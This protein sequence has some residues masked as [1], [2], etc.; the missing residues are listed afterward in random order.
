M[1]TR[2]AS[3]RWSVGHLRRTHRADDK[4]RPASPVT[5]KSAGRGAPRRRRAAEQRDEFA[6]LHSITSSASAS[7]LGGMSR[8][9]ALAEV[10]EQE[11]VGRQSPSCRN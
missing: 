11:E 5:L 10:D 4:S 7:S 9:S 3:P 2:L 6:A 8:P 1:V